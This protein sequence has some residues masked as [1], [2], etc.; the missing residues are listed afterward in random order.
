MQP[1]QVRLQIW[2]YDKKNIQCSGL[3]GVEACQFTNKMNRK[4]Y[5][6]N[7]IAK[8]LIEREDITTAK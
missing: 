6:P 8:K 3:R 7:H 5:R 1:K 4:N 2:P